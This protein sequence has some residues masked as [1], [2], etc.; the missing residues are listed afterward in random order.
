MNPMLGPVEQKNGV[1]T[2]SCRGA[3]RVRN[4]RGVVAMPKKIKNQVPGAKTAA[5]VT[6]TKRR[7]Y[8]LEPE[9][10]LTAWH[11]PAP[12]GERS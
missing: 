9:P 10:D 3:A 4:G 12:L 8:E 1:A 7:A 5:P 6:G 11:I 2:S